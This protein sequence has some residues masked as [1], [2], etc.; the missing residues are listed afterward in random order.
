M[1]STIWLK[2]HPTCRLLYPNAL[3]MAMRSRWV[4][5]S[6]WITTL[7]KNMAT[8]MKMAGN[9]VAMVLSWTSSS[10]SN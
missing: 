6:R 7:S 5:I 1:V 8:A 3:R 10:S 2:C 9:T 4:L